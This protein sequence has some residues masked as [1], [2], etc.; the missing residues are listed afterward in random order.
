MNKFEIIISKIL[1]E[2]EYGDAQRLFED[3]DISLYGFINENMD[4]TQYYIVSVCNSQYFKNVDF[5]EIQTEVYKGIKKVFPKE[6]SIEKNTSWLMGIE[7][8]YGYEELMNKILLIEENPYYFKKMVCPYLQVEVEGFLSEIGTYTNYIKYIQQEI[9][10]VNRFSDFRENKDGVYN[11]L[12][13]LLIKIPSIKLPI[14][15]ERKM[16]ILSDDIERAIQED[17]IQETYNFLR[18]NIDE[19]I[20]MI[21]EDIETLHGLYYGKDTDNE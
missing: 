9:L 13:R 5:E 11:F 4:N 21:D 10:K 19:K 14:D 7:C 1:K 20:S 3:E 15:K 16:R 6:P 2:L 18:E 8:E 17:D 12:S